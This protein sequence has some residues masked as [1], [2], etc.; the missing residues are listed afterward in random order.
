MQAPIAERKTRESRNL[1]AQ[2][3]MS[4]STRE[5]LIQNRNK[6]GQLEEPTVSLIT[7]NK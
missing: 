4:S 5:F 3:L 7:A 6:R 1:D 2:N